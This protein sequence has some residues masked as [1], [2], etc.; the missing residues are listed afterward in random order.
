M[1]PTGREYCQIYDGSWGRRRRRIWSGVFFLDDEDRAP[2][3]RHRNP[4]VTGRAL[5]GVGQA[6]FWL[7]R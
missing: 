7:G 1:E 4:T 2:V 3:G 6:Q 5:G